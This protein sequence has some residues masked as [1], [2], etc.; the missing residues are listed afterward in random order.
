MAGVERRSGEQGCRVQRGTRVAECRASSSRFERALAVH[1][2]ERVA[3]PSEGIARLPVRRSSGP[4][5]LGS[6]PRPLVRRAD[7]RLVRARIYWTR[8]TLP[9]I[10]GLTRETQERPA[11]S[12][13]EAGGVGEPHR[14]A[15]RARAGRAR[16]RDPRPAGA[17]R[18]RPSGAFPRRDDSESTH[19]QCEKASP[20]GREKRRDM[21][22][23]LSTHHCSR[24]YEQAML[25]AAASLPLEQPGLAAPRPSVRAPAVSSP[26]V[27]SPAVL[28]TA[29][30]GPARTAGPRP[31]ARCRSAAR[32]RRSSRAARQ[33]A[34]RQW[35]LRALG[36]GLA[37]PGPRGALS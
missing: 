30:P 8:L 31:S 27:S 16:G 15:W 21:E 37:A 12:R 1:A 2:R 24:W 20:S 18:R 29:A 26:A 23:P 5:S 7:P 17:L 10:S 11:S 35:Q 6:C 13:C 25:G 3:E 28:R 14:A 34:E 4:R 22:I 19:I 36:R 33:A 9:L 32:G